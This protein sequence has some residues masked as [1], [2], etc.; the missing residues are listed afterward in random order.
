VDGLQ[1]GEKPDRII[2][3]KL[4]VGGKLRQDASNGNTKVYI[5]GREITKIELRMLKVCVFLF[6]LTISIYQYLWLTQKL[7][8]LGI[9]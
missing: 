9:C 1:E 8:L 2:S 6:V 7:T 5:N 4:N 3:S